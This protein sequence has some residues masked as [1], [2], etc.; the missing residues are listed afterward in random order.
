VR[1]RF[2]ASIALLIVVICGLFLITD[3]PTP[4]AASDS[5]LF[6]ILTCFSINAT[7]AVL[8]FGSLNLS[9]SEIQYPGLNYFTPSFINP[10]QIFRV[11][12]SPGIE[13]TLD[14][15][16]YNEVS[17]ALG[18]VANFLDVHFSSTSISIVMGSDTFNSPGVPACSN[19][20]FTPTTITV[21]SISTLSV[22][23]Q[24]L[25]TVIGQGSGTLSPNCPKPAGCYEMVGN[26][27]TVTATPA[28]GY[29]FKSWKI[30]GASCANGDKA[31]PCTF[32]MP[33]N[34]VNVTVKF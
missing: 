32:T 33:N 2:A 18:D 34:P 27:I 5:L 13:V 6:P 30:E 4:V 22:M 29:A 31:N 17:W 21:T 10:P 23:V 26:L 25:V 16:L 19:V 15:T 9:G 12:F 20:Y 3:Y 14:P 8:G 24:P 28:T 11:G 7:E 1:A